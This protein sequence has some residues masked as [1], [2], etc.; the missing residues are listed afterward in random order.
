[1]IA[2]ENEARDHGFVLRGVVVSGVGQGSFYLSQPLYREQINA[3]FGFQP[4]PGTLNI[5]ISKELFRDIRNHALTNGSIL[6]GSRKGVG[7]EEHFFRVF[8]LPCQ[9]EGETVVALFPE[10]SVHDDE[11]ELISAVELRKKLTLKDG[12][13]VKIWVD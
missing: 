11:L 1:M 7:E 12:D 2:G 13:P 10:R 3:L 6:K 8:C 5:R 9:I 4:F